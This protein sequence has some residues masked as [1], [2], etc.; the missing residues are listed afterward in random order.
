MKKIGQFTYHGVVI[1][2]CDPCFR[3]GKW[4]VVCG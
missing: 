1:G 2:K 4:N 3:G